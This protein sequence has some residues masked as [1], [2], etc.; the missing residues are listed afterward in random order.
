M[1][2]QK[3][4]LN[5]IPKTSKLYLSDF[6]LF[7]KAIYQQA[8]AY[9][10]EKKD[11]PEAELH[12]IEKLIENYIAYNFHQLRQIIDDDFFEWNQSM[13]IFVT[14]CEWRANLPITP[15]NDTLKNFKNKYNMLDPNVNRLSEAF[16]LVEHIDDRWKAWQLQ[17][18]PNVIQYIKKVHR[19]LAKYIV[20]HNN[21]RTMDRWNMV[22]CLV[23]DV[24][25]AKTN[26]VMYIGAKV[27]LQLHQ[28]E[29]AKFVQSMLH[30]LPEKYSSSEKER[31]H[32]YD[33]CI[34]QKTYYTIRNF[35]MR[36]SAFL[37]LTLHDEAS[38]AY[39]TYERAGEVPTVYSH[40]TSKY[41]NGWIGNM[42][43]EIL[44]GQPKELIYNDNKDIKECA[45]LATM[46]AAIKTLYT[47]E[48]VK[49]CLC[50]DDAV[51][52]FKRHLL[53]SKHPIILRI[54]GK[55]GI[56]HGEKFYD[57][58]SLID[59]LITWFKILRE[60][61]GCTLLENIN[62]MNLINQLLPQQELIDL[63][64]LEDISTV[65]RKNQHYTKIFDVI[66]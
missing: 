37:W 17:D 61:F 60:E 9:N 56:M 7:W 38:R 41:P 64:T 57:T 54:W 59:T 44:Y 28:I 29:T 50:V 24:Y 39:H 51:L 1:D 14:L 45:I 35:R 11:I 66:L 3:I 26:A 40:V 47:M 31:K 46:E 6:I 10:K 30:V 55:W 27:A 15:L 52:K 58:N 22:D 5:D 12:N 62:M 18:M 8:F 65:Q 49:Y 42:Q 19:S 23:K 33:W 48:F 2:F 43:H 4:T 53:V 21:I 25:K 34:E 32:I 13:V 36:I 20:R 16:L 63:P